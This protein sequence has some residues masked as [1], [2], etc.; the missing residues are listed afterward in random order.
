MSWSLNLRKPAY[1]S[2][3]GWSGCS[4]AGCQQRHVL[5]SSQDSGWCGLG[6]RFVIRSSNLMRTS[7]C[8]GLHM[9]TRRFAFSSSS[10]SFLNLSW[11]MRDPETG[12]QRLLRRFARHR[13][14]HCEVAHIRLATVL[15]S[16][17]RAAEVPCAFEGAFWLWMR[18]VL[19]EETRPFQGTRCS[20]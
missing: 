18:M 4:A 10:I 15:P 12:A 3:H 14:G 2:F 5:P 16:R 6:L 13:C 9:H 19:M 17:A 7:E 8:G 11:M 20:K 1:E